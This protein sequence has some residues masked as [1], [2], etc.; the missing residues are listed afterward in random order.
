MKSVYF[1]NFATAS[2]VFVLG[3]LMVLKIILPNAE[4]STR[5]IFG[6]IFI[7]YGIYRYV[8]TQT[9]IKEKKI[10]EQRRRMEKAQD[11]LI[12]KK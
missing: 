6:V 8:T 4:P 11:E 10:E 5:I 7:A 12:H 3:I 9:K 1:I 2:I